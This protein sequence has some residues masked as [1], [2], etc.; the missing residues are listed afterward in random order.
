MLPHEMLNF[1]LY[2]SLKQKIHYSILFLLCEVWKN[3]AEMA[4]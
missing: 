3:K 4:L 2:N 1:G